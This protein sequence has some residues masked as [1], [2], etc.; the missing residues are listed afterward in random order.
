[1]RA[2]LVQHDH[3][4]AS[5]PVGHRLRE[6]GFEIDEIMVVTEENFE[7]PNVNFE[8]P[9][10]SG[11][12]LVVPMGAPWGAWDDGCIGK[13]LTPE[14]E[15]VRSAIEAD[16]PVLGICFGG[17]LIARAL[18]GTVARGAQSEIGW[19]TIYSDDTSLV[20]NGPWFQFH[21][22]QWT[23]PEGAVEIARNPI[24][25]QAFTY[26]RSLAVQFHPELNSAILEGWLDQG[27]I[28]E[29]IASGQN[30][31]IMIAQTRDEEGRAAERTAAL[32]DAFLERIAKLV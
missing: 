8:F 20:S 24:A 16:I 15:W 2:L 31:E 1:M 18:G 4:T 26:G 13:W 17:Q 5:G 14:L 30:P 23:M 19:K 22:D 27:G 32:V 12:D 6:R 9:D 29:V 28:N 11:Y 25:P 21:Y 10:V 3:V 7:N